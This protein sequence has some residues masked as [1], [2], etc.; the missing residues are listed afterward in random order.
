M[1]QDNPFAKLGALDQKLYQETAP[2]SEVKST[3]KVPPAK[4]QNAGIPASQQSSI[5]A[6]HIS[7]KLASQNTG[8]PDIQQT[9]NIRIPANVT[10]T[11]KVTYRFHAEGKYAVEDMKTILVRKH[12]IKA[13]LEEIAEASILMAYEDLL[14][15]QNASK[16][17]HRLSRMPAN[18]KTS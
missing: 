18:K 6:R 12:G 16:L 7:S 17:A 5:P 14:E 15:N 1:K 13:S 2:K 9:G 8:K 10:A 4:S 11:E 3:E